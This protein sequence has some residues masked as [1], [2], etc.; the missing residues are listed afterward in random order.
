MSPDRSEMQFDEML[1]GALKRHKNFVPTNFPEKIL[2]QITR[3]QEQ[4]I[5]ARV[6]MQ[7]R[8]ALMGCIVLAVMSITA[9]A[10]F[11]ESALTAASQ[12]SLLIARTCKTIT[13]DF[14]S[15]WGFTLVLTIVFGFA[16]YILTDLLTLND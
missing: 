3:Q 7:E 16:V 11:P 6:V 10:V 5:L 14:F 8:L 13:A 4:K 1:S 15:D 2:N 9:V 12:F